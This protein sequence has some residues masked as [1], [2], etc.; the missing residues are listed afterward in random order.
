M[1]L[2][3]TLAPV[4]IVLALLWTQR[5]LETWLQ[6]H[7][8]KV[9]W[10]VT[11]DLLTTT[12]IYYLL[13]LPGV[14]LHEI[15]LWLTAGILNVRADRAIAWPEAQQA[16][17]LRINFVKVAKNASAFK[18][19]IIHTAPLAVGVGL[20]YL[21]ANNVLNVDEFLTLLGSGAVPFD[22]ALGRL[23]ATP[24]LFLWMYVIFTLGTTMWPDVKMLK[25]W[26]IVVI[27]AGAIVLALYALG[28]G[29]AVLLNGLARPVSR[30]LNILSF[31]VGVVIAIHLFITAL[32]GTIEALIER[33]TGDSATF[34]NGKL[35][36]MRR[37]ERLKLEAEQRAKL[38]KKRQQ[39]AE[40]AASR[41][42]LSG[43]PSIYKLPLP[44]PDAPGKETA[45]ID[46][47]L[48]SKAPPGQPALLDDARAG[49]GVIT[50][51][52]VTRPTFTPPLPPAATGESSAP[53]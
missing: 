22:F 18:L 14:L 31:A 47:A 52:A 48:V 7:L 40:R 32:L 4:V 1:I 45:L 11:K 20:I 5:K 6:Q 46:G 15:V 12:R 28:I 3:E 24:D 19:A 29:D 43:P 35:V 50:G 25:G 26:R 23:L 21:I 36:A 10:L 9:G 37:D 42:A 44:I 49:A 38:E 8:F 13:F 39:E 51:K 2:F 17:E 16:A 34:Q 41:A 27:V 33:I 30:A 53:E